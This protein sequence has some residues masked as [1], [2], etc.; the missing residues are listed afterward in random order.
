MI[1]RRNFSS[2]RGQLFINKIIALRFDE[3]VFLDRLRHDTDIIE[4]DQRRKNYCCCCCYFFHDRSLIV[5][6][7]EYVRRDPRRVV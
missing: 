4:I 5:D 1:L 3:L 7:R 6:P 2:P